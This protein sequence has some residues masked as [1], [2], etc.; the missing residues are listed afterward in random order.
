[1]HRTLLLSALCVLAGSSAAAAAPTPLAALTARLAPSE[2][3]LSFVTTDEAKERLVT[4]AKQEAIDL[5][6]EPVNRL[7]QRT[8]RPDLARFPALW[9]TRAAQDETRRRLNAASSET[10]P[11]DLVAVELV[12]HVVF[13]ERHLFVVK[14]RDQRVPE[15]D[16]AQRFLL[17]FDAAGALAD[18]ALLFDFRHDAQVRMCPEAHP[19]RYSLSADGAFQVSLF[20]DPILWNVPYSSQFPIDTIPIFISATGQ[21]D[22]EG[23]MA[24]LSISHENANGVFR[25]PKSKEEVVVIEEAGSA[26]IVYRAGPKK[27]Y[28]ELR[29]S[30]GDFDQGLV[31]HFGD[32]PK[33]YVLTRTSHLEVRCKNPDGTEQKFQRVW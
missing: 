16:F 8:K 9:G 32:S 22:A 2:L 5:V 7:A 12:A 24:P 26:R 30:S 18:A 6:I 4:L 23:R 19:C 21:L 3:P 10:A 1:M 13:K 14:V 17:T 20:R 28:Q 11:P 29:V 15:A 27:K 33:P 31:T 25:D